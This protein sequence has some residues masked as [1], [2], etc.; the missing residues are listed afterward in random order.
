MIEG[1][2]VIHE[3]TYPHPP[4]RVWRALVDP[5]E[6]ALWLMVGDFAAVVGRR[7]TLQCDPIGRVQA[8]VLGVDAPRRLC[9]RWN[10]SFGDTVVTFELTPIAT[11][12]RLRVE[13]RGWDEAHLADR[14][15]FE[16]GW[17]SKLTIGLRRVLEAAPTISS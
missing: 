2:S 9:C 3:V 10:G 1:E 11:G 5:D 15:R 8:E 14:D 16:G 13:H 7:F 4:E 12:T 6:L 17:T